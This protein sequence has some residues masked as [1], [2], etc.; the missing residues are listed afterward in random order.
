MPEC[1]CI[2]CS[3][4]A[5]VHREQEGI[6]MQTVSMSYLAFQIQV[7]LILDLACPMSAHLFSSEAAVHRR[8]DEIRMQTVCITYLAFQIQG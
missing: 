7:L 4:E 3:S 8:Q 5:A 2:S 1:L 6:R